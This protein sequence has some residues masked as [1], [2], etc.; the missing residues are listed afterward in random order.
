MRK[1]CAIALAA[2]VLLTSGTV[3]AQDG[4]GADLIGVPDGGYAPSVPNPA[5]YAIYLSPKADAGAAAQARRQFGSVTVSVIGASMQKDMAGNDCLVVALR[6]SHS[7]SE[8]ANFLFSVVMTA[9]QAAQELQP[10]LP[11]QGYAFGASSEPIMPGVEQSVYYFLQPH[12]LQ[13]DIYLSIAEFNVDAMAS[14]NSLDVVFKL[15]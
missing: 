9:Q 5:A 6:W 11:V 10:G 13:S 14:G 7:R 3:W 12:D 15:L 4:E 2:L 8:P 1:V